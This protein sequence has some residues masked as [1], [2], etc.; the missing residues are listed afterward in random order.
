MVVAAVVVVGAGWWSMS[1]TAAAG[2]SIAEKIMT[3][4]THWYDR[5]H[6]QMDLCC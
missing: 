5:D 6:Q 3:S 2:I 1:V 4:I